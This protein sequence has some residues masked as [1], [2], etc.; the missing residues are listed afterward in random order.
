MSRNASGS[1]QRHPSIDGSD[2]RALSARGAPAALD[3][4]ITKL[5]VVTKQLLQGL[6]Q[7][8]QGQLSEDD[9]SD[10][11]VRLGNGFELCI[12]AFR[13]AGIK[14][15]DLD[16]VPSDL[17]VVL[18][19]GL[20]EEPSQETLSQY[21]PEIRAIIYH[22]LQGLKSKQNAYKRIVADRQVMDAYA[23]S[24][25]VG[26]RA[27]ASSSGSGSGAAAGAGVGSIGVGAGMNSSTSSGGVA[28]PA[29]EATRPIPI[30]QAHARGGS[31]GRSSEDCARTGPDR[32]GHEAGGRVG[33]GLAASGSAASDSRLSA[34][35][36]TPDGS[37]SPGSVHSQLSTSTS[38]S[39]AAPARA[40]APAA[41]A[42]RARQ[43]SST[44]PAPPDAFR[45]ARRPSDQ[46]RA[47]S[48][49]PPP[50]ASLPDAHPLVRHQLVD[51][52]VPVS[53][54]D[55]P[56]P[57]P[58]PTAS[59]TSASAAVSAVP[60]HVAAPA[61]LPQRTPPH[62]D[63]FSRDSFGNA[64]N[65][66]RFSVDSDLT[67]GSPSSTS[68]SPHIARL[69][70]V[71]EPPAVPTTPP[72]PAAPTPPSLPVLNLPDVTLAESDQPTPDAMAD[73]D[74]VDEATSR[75]TLAALQ[76]SDALERRA[77]KRFSSFTFNKM[78][79]GSPSGK[80]GAGSSGSPQRPQRRAERDRA[81]PMP[82]VPESIASLAAAAIIEEPEPTPTP[83]LAPAL[84][85][86]ESTPLR[87]RTPDLVPG[88]VGEQATP[89]AQASPPS[90]P[91]SVSVFLQLGRQVKKTTVELP[92]ALSALRLLFMERF[93]YDPGLEDFPDVYVRDNRTGVQY[94]LEDMDDLKEGVVLSL[95]I[96]P[97]DQV[98]QHFDLTF[99]SLSQE[100]K[101][102][103]T[104]L[105]TRRASILPAAALL[106]PSAS[107]A[108]R[109]LGASPES[110]P[111]PLSPSPS[112]PSSPQLG[113]TASPGPGPSLP[114]SGHGLAPAE[115]RAQ[116]DEVQNLRRDLAVM[117][118]VHVD[119]LAQTKESFASLR[120]QNTAM[121]D[122]VKTKM[123]GSRALLDHSKAKIEAQ[124]QDTIEAVEDVSDT[125]D[126]AREDALRRGITPARGQLDRI[127]ADL[128]KA[129]A[130]VDAFAHDVTLAEPTWRATWAH[131]LSRVMEEQ[132]LLAYQ[133]K[134]AADLKND[135]KDA[136]DML[137][138]VSAFVGQ[139]AAAAGAGAGR[140]GAADA[141]PTR[142]SKPFLRP[143]PESEPAD[144]IGNLLLEIRTKDADPTSRLRAIEQQQRAREKELASRT[145]AFSAELSG[146][147]GGRKLRRTGGT[148]E[149][150]RV[151]QRRHDQTVKRMLSGGGP[152]E[153]PGMLSPQATGASLAG[154]LVAQT[155][156]GSARSLVTPT[157]P[158]TP[159]TPSTP[160]TA[161]TRGS[162]T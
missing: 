97:L 99:A 126:G 106:V 149:A 13:R 122:V 159:V 15:K 27:S 102:L 150:E 11:Y 128:A 100:I 29:H 138:N 81:P 56:P 35:A 130:Q 154:G 69:A 103:K 47:E 144:G 109:P 52:P 116:Y 50:P 93:E 86:V 117:R 115:L 148:E 41:L 58:S 33:G 91:M 74:E 34:R 94:E 25:G 46:R 129:T 38:L 22:L 45:P 65:Q 104:V 87:A 64:R 55:S 136:T 85:V 7:W 79:P 146:F 157:T 152:D 83:T 80:K 28:R 121:R 155:T 42:E 21:L 134:L 2:A 119:F 53:L 44:R 88:D 124:C 9:V 48:P 40:P 95:D 135:I 145:D 114:P 24:A 62:P 139:K 32:H 70:E 140:G 76:R 92:T 5:L 19:K 10:I 96:E 39:A 110:A 61:R 60:A 162:Q 12:T 127:R 131:E 107:T 71:P 158:A 153:G 31:L 82:A 67:H 54:N 111:R 105:N 90:R 133:N 1:T 66:S 78:L 108:G 30:P 118:Q 68:H 161:S 14:T 63:R 141:G 89:R 18:E 4:Y 20:A 147:V 84:A 17:R 72:A 112:K 8:A 36:A 16:S 123:G 113:A 75:S 77:S 3:S 59:S 37:A 23:T 49:L 73:A 101:E 125:I 142:A 43:G 156:G 143:V 26:T 6:E 132:R 51:R 57:P 98:K 120:A 137:D 151:R 160:N